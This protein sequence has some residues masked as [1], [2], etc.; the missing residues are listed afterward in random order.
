[1]PRLANNTSLQEIEWQRIIHVDNRLA[2]VTGGLRA[3]RWDGRYAVL[4]SLYVLFYGSWVS[5]LSFF[6]IYLQQMGLSGVQIGAVNGIRP[7][8]MLLSQPL[9]GLLADVKGRR[10]VLLFTL[11]AGAFLL[12]GYTQGSGFQFVFF[13]TILYTL[14]A[15]PI[16]A[17]IDSLVLDHTLQRPRLSFG[18]L[19][20]WGAVGWAVFSLLA[21]R[22]VSGHSLN[23]IFSMG[24]ILLLIALLIAWRSGVGSE[25]SSRRLANW[26]GAAQLLRNRRLLAA[27]GV[28]AAMQTGIACYYTFFSIYLADLNAPRT[29]IGAAYTVQGLGE[30]PIFLLSA[31]IIR[32]V[33][34]RGAIGL[35]ICTFGCRLL[36]YSVITN[37][38]LAVSLGLTHGIAFSLFL[39]AMV[40]YIAEQVPPHLRATGQSLYWAAFFGAGAILGNAWAGVLYDRL[41]A[42]P[43]F[44]LNGAF[45]LLVAAL[46]LAA[47]RPQASRLSA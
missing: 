44:A 43:M 16:G 29:L 3:L 2:A 37:P 36:L 14:A 28:A 41:G 13:W 15:N 19:R 39:V 47:I 46:A 26:Q 30:L 40:G 38:L 12:M 5:W 22:L 4:S 24:A 25:Q 42:R 34:A 23:P 32:R 8:V 1:M 9:W 35:A 27:L 11:G 21:G 33:G 45:L 17:L 7:A 10:Q 18:M 31:A 6:A 20:I